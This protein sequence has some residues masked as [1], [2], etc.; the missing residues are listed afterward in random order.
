MSF[1]DAVTPSHPSRYNDEDT[2]P[3]TPR[4]LRG[5]YSYAIAAEVFAVVGVGMLSC[6]VL[7]FRIALLWQYLLVQS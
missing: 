6:I 5:W 4:E 7:L 3:T 1:E 2:S